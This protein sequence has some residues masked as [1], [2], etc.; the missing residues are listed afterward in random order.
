M[1]G[2]YRIAEKNIEICSLHEWVHTLCREYRV[3]GQVDLRV[4]I[5]SEDIAHERRVSE[6]DFSDA[7][8]ESLAVLRKIVEA[9]PAWDT[10]LFHSSA[11]EVDG[12]VYLFA[13]P[14]GTGKS[15]HARLWRELLGD[16]AHTINDDKPFLRIT[17]EGVTV[18][19]TPWNG[20]HALG[21]NC[22][23]PLRAICFLSQAKENAIHAATRDEIYFNLLDQIYRPY[24]AEALAKTLVLIDRLC[25]HTA[26]YRLE[27][28]MDP[29]AAR[30]SYTTMSGS[31]A[32]PE[33]LIHEGENP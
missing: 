30:L 7:Y 27:C 18:F 4:E 22:S 33:L 5:V 28:N 6:E 10:I 31:T 8:L 15:T 14:S 13:A 17:D 9:M 23:A 2:L 21:E 16:R 12:V 20:K 24:S 3:E 11:I 32:A 29:D 26:F 25:A 1:T 19:G